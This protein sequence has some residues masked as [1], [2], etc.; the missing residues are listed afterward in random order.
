METFDPSKHFTF[1]G[2]FRGRK[3]EMF[4]H[5]YPLDAEWEYYSIRK[6]QPKGKPSETG[7]LVCFRPPIAHLLIDTL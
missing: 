3:L 5:P 7:E 2:S 6:I 1:V 4:R